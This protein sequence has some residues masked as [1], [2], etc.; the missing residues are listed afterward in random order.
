MSLSN[1]Q[2]VSSLSNPYNTPRG[3]REDYRFFLKNDMFLICTSVRL[4]F[5]VA[6]YVFI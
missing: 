6:L 2:V 3:I 4:S 5:V 1:L